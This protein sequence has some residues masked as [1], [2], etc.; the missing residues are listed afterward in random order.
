M[1]SRKS[2]NSA[3]IAAIDVGTN[4]V[5]MVVAR[6]GA[7]GFQV[8]SSEKEVVRMGSGTAGMDLLAP[9]AIDRA[10]NALGRMK[11]IADAHH[12]EIR[13]VA[14]SAVREATNAKEFLQR[15]KKEVGIAVEVISGNEEA[16]LI[17]LGVQHSLALGTESVLTVDIGGGSTEFCV[18][19]KGRLRIAQSVKVGAVRLTDAFLP[20]GDSDESGVRRLRAHIASVIAPLAH[21]I[22]EMGF[23]RVV[24]SSGTSE[25]IARLIA[26]ERGGRLPQSMNGFSFTK[27][28]FAAVM[29]KI[30][31]TQNSRSRQEL[32]GM[33]SK[34]SDIIVAGG[35]ILDEITKALRIDSFEFSEYALR[36]G[37]LVD[38]AQKRG[39][40]QNDVVDAGLGSVLRLAERCSVDLVHSNHVAFLSRKILTLVSRR[41]DVD[42]SLGRLL[43]SA[44]LLANVGNAVSYSKHHLHSY[45]IIRNADLMG[46]TDEEIEVIALTARYHRKG[47][48]KLSHSEFAKMP[49]DRQHDIELMAGIIRIATG[50]DRS[51]DQSVA[52]I[53]MTL[54]N[55]IM[56]LVPRHAGG[57]SDSAALNVFTAQ[58]RV[59][60]LQD[61]LGGTVTIAS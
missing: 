53:S 8:L 45:Y 14:T 28:E 59:G 40:L 38:V 36:E 56:T 47:A 29:R 3:V 18:S 41:F 6:I 33:D 4:S 26:H 16:R 61:F 50:L 51:H 10:I 37:V 54:R 27:G 20:A 12:A 15:A 30:L 5:H 44:A 34:R 55:E 17:H 43:E 11:Q 23:S 21:E 25:T 60:L 57:S 58:E 46:F 24:L 2:K 42:A 32:P 7:H 13:A 49:E 48:P 22:R 39:L 35:V 52:D 1:K 19:T 9:E 31:G